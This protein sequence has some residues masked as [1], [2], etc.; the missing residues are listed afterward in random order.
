MHCDVVFSSRDAEWRRRQRQEPAVAWVMDWK[1]GMFE[2]GQEHRDNYPF[3]SP[4]TT[5][6][7]F[8]RNQPV[9]Q[10]AKRLLPCIKRLSTLQQLLASQCHH[11]LQNRDNIFFLCSSSPHNKATLLFADTQLNT[12]LCPYVGPCVGPSV[13][14]FVHLFVSHTRVEKCE[15]AHLRCCGCDCMRVCMFGGGGCMPLPSRL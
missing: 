10:P 12:R 6:F 1:C 13:G 3:S 8:P 4:L 9:V 7:L 15:N 2:L 11:P 14:P 5:S